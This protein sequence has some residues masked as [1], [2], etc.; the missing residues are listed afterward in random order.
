MNGEQF[1]FD[2]DEFGDAYVFSEMAA[3]AL[4]VNREGL[5]MSKVTAASFPR[6]QVLTTK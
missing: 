4:S 5:I 2:F 6:S 1:A 3:L